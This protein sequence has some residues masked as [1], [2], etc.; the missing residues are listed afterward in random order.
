MSFQF[1]VFRSTPPHRTVPYTTPTKNLGGE[2]GRKVF[3]ERRVAHASDPERGT[4]AS[5]PQ[6]H[7]RGVLR[8]DEFSAGHHGAVRVVVKIHPEKVQRRR[9]KLDTGRACKLA[10]LVWRRET[11][12][13]RTPRAGVGGGVGREGIL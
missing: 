10:K 2:Q 7:G 13:V 3:S 9:Q 11:I 1:F 4:G 5:D 6:N 12:S 8:G